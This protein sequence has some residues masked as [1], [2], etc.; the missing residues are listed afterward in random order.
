MVTA[1]VLILINLCA[2]GVGIHK[3]TK[4]DDSEAIFV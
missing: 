2:K 3:S 4:N 1:I